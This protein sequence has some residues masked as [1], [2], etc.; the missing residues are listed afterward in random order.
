MKKGN[1][2]EKK[3][4]HKKRKKKVYFEIEL[5]KQKEKKQKDFLKEVN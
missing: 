3:L 5:N 2:E 1:A 4:V